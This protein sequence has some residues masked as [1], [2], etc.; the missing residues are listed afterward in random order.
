MSLANSNFTPAEAAEFAMLL[1]VTAKCKP[2]NIDRLHDYDDTSMSHFLSS[3]ARAREVFEQIDGLS[4][5]QAFYNAVERTNNHSGGNTHF[6]AFIL[7]L[8]LLKGRGIEGAMRQTAATDVED[9]VLFYKAFGL[10]QVRTNK[11]SEMDV[12]DPESI[13]ML[14]EKKM[15]MLDVMQ[16]SAKNDMVAREWTN[17]FALTKECAAL[18]QS[19][20]GA[21]KIS[22][23]FLKMM[24]RHADTFVAKKFD[25]ETAESVK[26]LAQSVLDGKTTAESFDAF[27]LKEGINPGS[28]ADICIAGIFVSLLEGWNW[29]C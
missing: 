15:T 14:Y 26:T 6:G 19:A 12:N 29:D 8:P 11:E 9:A 18:L 24:A 1:E 20:G 27:C 7:L 4:L 16:M 5:G 10:T 21:S 3:A 13:H 28:L 23:V 25:L 17:G 2:G 22:D